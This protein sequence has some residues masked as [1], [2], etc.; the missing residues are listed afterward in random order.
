M[1]QEDRPQLYLLTPPAFD[2]EVFPSQL[3]KVLDAVEVAC[4]RLTMATK[5]EDQIG[6]AADACRMVAHERDVA[7]VIETHLK[8]VERHG[9]DGVHLTDA[10][11]TIRYARKELGAD[12]IVGAWC[13]DSR[14]DGMNAAEAGADYV[15]FGPVGQTALG[16]GTPAELDLFQ[17]W[18]EMIEVPVV[19]EGA[20]T[21]ELIRTL[22]PMTDFFAIGEEIWNTE[23]PAQALRALVA[24]MG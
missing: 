10:A 11:R 8:L 2:L 15:C 7:L 1:A 24:A 18:S 19:A 22:T 6:R 16:T 17:W 20:L 4:I 14:H 9:L 12:A 3:A 5:D 13:A 21:P 23:D